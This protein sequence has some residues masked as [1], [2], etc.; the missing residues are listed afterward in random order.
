MLRFLKGRFPFVRSDQSDWP[1][2]KWDARVMRT[3]GTGSGQTGPAHGEGPLRA[4]QFSRSRVCR[5]RE[6]RGNSTR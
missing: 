4:A 6:V 2:C 3:V 1:V 5:T